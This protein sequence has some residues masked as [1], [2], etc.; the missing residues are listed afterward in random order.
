MMDNEILDE[1][2]FHIVTKWM[3]DV[4]A[5]RGKQLLNKKI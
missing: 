3:M 2:Y 1:E 4:R 5:D